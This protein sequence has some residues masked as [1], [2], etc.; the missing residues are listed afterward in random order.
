MKTKHDPAKHEWS[1][2]SDFVLDLIAGKGEK[3]WAP[4]ARRHLGDRKSVV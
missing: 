3:K 4:A 2:L 1:T